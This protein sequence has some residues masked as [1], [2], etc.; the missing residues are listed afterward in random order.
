MTTIPNFGIPKLI[1]PYIRGSFPK[2][3]P[4]IRG[5]RKKPGTSIGTPK[6]PGVGGPGVYPGESI[7][8]VTGIFNLMN[9]YDYKQL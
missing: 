3:I 4:Y 5:S 6:N 7:V 1:F 9:Q 2:P 8:P